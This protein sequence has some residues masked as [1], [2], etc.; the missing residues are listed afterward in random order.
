MGIC[1]GVCISAVRT[2]LHCPVQPNVI[3]LFIGFGVGQCEHTISSMIYNSSTVNRKI[4]EL[5]T[6]CEVAPLIQTKQ[7]TKITTA[8]VI[9]KSETYI[10]IENTKAC[11]K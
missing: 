9:Y 2:P 8:T 11:K 6:F 4:L 5:T 3:S 1:V 7:R 10:S